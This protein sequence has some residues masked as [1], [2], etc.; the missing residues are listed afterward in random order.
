MYNICRSVFSKCT[1]FFYKTQFVFF[2]VFSSF[3]CHSYTFE[4]VLTTRG[5]WCGGLV[6]SCI[7]VV[8]LVKI[9]NGV[10]SL[11]S[12]RLFQIFR[13]WFASFV[14]KIA[15]SLGTILATKVVWNAA[16]NS[17]LVV[18]LLAE[19]WTLRKNRLLVNMPKKSNQTKMIPFLSLRGFVD[20][21]ESGV[22]LWAL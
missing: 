4:D 15:P 17:K 9:R 20:L 11:E 2:F 3:D 13:K 5:D 22:G 18:L 7:G 21:S 10:L 1:H 19:R 8:T 12:P 6:C 16:L 14:R